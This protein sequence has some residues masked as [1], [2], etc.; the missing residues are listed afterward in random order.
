MIFR[1]KTMLGFNIDNFRNN[2]MVAVERLGGPTKA[3][4]AAGVSNATIHNWIKRKFI[5]NIDKAKLMAS[6]T[7]LTVQQLRATR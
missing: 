6:L 5:S 3:A 7:G 2:I 1:G 4:H